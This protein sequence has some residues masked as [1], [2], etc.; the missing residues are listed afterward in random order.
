MREIDR[1]T[2]EQEARLAEERQYWLSNGRSTEPLD[3]TKATD[4]IHALY[5]ALGRPTPTVL[6]FSSPALCITAWRAF[7]EMAEVPRESS[8]RHDMRLEPQLKAQLREQLASQPISKQWVQLRKQAALSI[9]MQVE[10][11]QRSETWQHVWDELCTHFDS[12]IDSRLGP[13]LRARLEL[14]LRAPL[15]SQLR[16]QLWRSVEWQINEQLGRPIRLPHE[17]ESTSESNEREDDPAELE[18][19]LFEITRHQTVLDDMEVG[20]DMPALEVVPTYLRTDIWEQ[21]GACMGAW[22]CASAVYYG[23]CGRIGF[24]YALEQ[25]RILRLW[26]DQCRHCHWW[27]ECDGIVFL[28]D[29]PMVLQVDSQGRL[30]DERSATLAYGDGFSLYAIHG[31]R[32]DEDAVLH[33]EH[34]RVNR[35][36]KEIDLEVR[37][38]LISV[39]GQARYIKDSGAILVHQDERGKLWRKK[40]A[41][42]TDLVMVEVLNSTPELGSSSRSYMLRVP[43]NMRTA[44][45]AVAWT[46]G[47]RSSQYRPSVET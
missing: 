2:P 47:M 14:E 39:Y 44:S 38:A 16:S 30:H 43:P 4:A 33:P 8:R 20:I 23:F 3:R 22:W 17:T 26:L 25:K 45:A 37:R 5:A 42:D 46:F 32:L 6:F 28:S 34:I 35:I 9:R 13:Q 15:W 10:S 21:V 27:F 41:G 29:R 18:R 19:Q 12:R 7:R 24:L 40:R 31:V 11:R 1:M 36:E